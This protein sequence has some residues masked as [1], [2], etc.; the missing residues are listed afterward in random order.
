M[1]LNNVKLGH[2][3]T[4]MKYLASAVSLAYLPKNLIWNKSMFPTLNLMNLA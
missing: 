4:F 2:V 1:T 3:V